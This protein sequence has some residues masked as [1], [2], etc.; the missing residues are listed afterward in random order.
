MEAKNSTS[1]GIDCM[2]LPAWWKKS[3]TGMALKNET[4][5]SQRL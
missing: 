2:A 1:G 3:G 4:M 5:P